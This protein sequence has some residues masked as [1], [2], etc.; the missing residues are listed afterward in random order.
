[1]K[2]PIT[3]HKPILQSGEYF[4]IE[5]SSDGVT[6]TFDSYQQSNTFLTNSSSFVAGN[7]Y[8]FKFSIVKSM[9]PYVECD[10]VVR[11]YSIPNVADCIDDFTVTMEQNGNSYN[12]KIA[13]NYPIS[14]TMPCGGFVF[15][16]GT[17]YPLTAIQYMA[18]PASPFS[19]PVPAGTYFYELYVL[20]C[21]GKESMCVL[22]SVIYQ[23]PPCTAATVS[24]ATLTKKNNTRYIQFN[25]A[26]SSPAASSYTISYLQTNNNLAGNIPDS[27]TV[28]VAATPAN[29]QTIMIPVNPNYNVVNYIGINYSVSVTDGCGKTIIFDLFKDF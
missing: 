11:A 3:I 4:K 9:S 29:P 14:Y 20:D 13:Y 26:H 5:Y 15:K 22:G 10:A 1:M 23:K 2:L 18:L 12:L 28:T 7:T 6:W 8:Y 27:G 24:S 16:Y 25:I 17:S 21:N 19:I